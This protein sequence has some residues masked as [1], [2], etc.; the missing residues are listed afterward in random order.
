MF[1]RYQNV[2]GAMLGE[3]QVNVGVALPASAPDG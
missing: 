2:G 1:K 3:S